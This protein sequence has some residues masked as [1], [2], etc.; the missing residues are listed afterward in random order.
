MRA[1]HYGKWLCVSK[2]CGGE[3]GAEVVVGLRNGA[4]RCRFP[5]GSQHD[6]NERENARKC[7]PQK[8]S[9]TMQK[10]FWKIN[11]PHQ[12]PHTPQSASHV[13]SV[14]AE[15][16]LLG[17]VFYLHCVYDTSVGLCAL[18]SLKQMILF[19]S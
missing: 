4:Q 9:P 12:C 15:K 11:L 10:Y 13:S 16:P 18:L 14:R 19:A 1:T 8:Q 2:S 6:Q 3:G 17:V 5:C 7:K